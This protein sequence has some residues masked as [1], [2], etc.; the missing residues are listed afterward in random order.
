MGAYE[1]DLLS[2][3]PH[4]IIRIATIR[5]DENIAVPK[6]WVDASVDNTLKITDLL[7]NNPNI[8]WSE[9]LLLMKSVKP[10]LGIEFLREVG[11]LS[12]ILPELLAC[13][14]V[15]QNPEYHT[16]DVYHHCLYSCD[17]CIKDNP[18]LRFAALIHDV[19]KPIVRDEK[20]VGPPD[21]S[22]KRELKVTFHKHEVQSSRLTRRITR[23]FRV[24]WTDSNFIGDLVSNHMYQYDRVWKDST[25]RNFVERVNLMPYLNDMSKFP[26]FQLRYADRAGRGLQPCTEKQRD[27]EDRIRLV[28]SEKPID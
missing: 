28:M 10:S 24:N 16:Y 11:A 14:G 17:C 21:A 5:S 7:Y 26:L 18:L 13:Y 3:E 4:L 6:E 12:I 22:G 1:R 8:I 25:V 9:I 2:K 20:Y 15:T 19:G 27:F 23:R